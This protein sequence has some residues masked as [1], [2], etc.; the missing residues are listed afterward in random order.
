MI[1]RP[2]GG[3]H[4]ALLAVSGGQNL[5]FPAF[6]NDCFTPGSGR[7]RMIVAKGG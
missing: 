1:G 3:D 4:C 2:L 7:S 5:V 6:L